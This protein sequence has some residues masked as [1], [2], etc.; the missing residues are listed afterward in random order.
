MACDEHRRGQKSVQGLGGKVRRKR[1]H[2]E[3]RGIDVR[4]TSEWI[5]WACRMDS[6]GSE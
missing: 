6:D 2:S 4:M 1:D 5:G 3:E